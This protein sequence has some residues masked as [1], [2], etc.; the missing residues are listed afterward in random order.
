LS[1]ANQKGLYQ[2]LEALELQNKSPASLEIKKLIRTIPDYPSPG[3]M[4]RDVT[5]LIGHSKGLNTAIECLTQRYRQEKLAKVAGIEARGFIFGAILAEKLGIGFVPIRKQG[6]LPAQ[7][8]SQDYDLEYG[9]GTLEIHTDAIATS[10]KILLVDDLLA[11]GGTAEAAADLIQKCSGVVH[12]CCFIIDLPDL[13][14]SK[15]LKRAGHSV[16]S[17]CEFEGE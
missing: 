5:T 6:K 3:I 15:R 7:T 16:F 12:E 2:P 11:T 17:I 1:C 13:G 9:S 10:E 14:G 8:F 4:Y